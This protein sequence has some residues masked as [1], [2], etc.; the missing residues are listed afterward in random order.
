MATSSTITIIKPGAEGDDSDFE[1]P[2][3]SKKINR[4]RSQSA[5]GT[6]DSGADGS[7]LKP[8][9]Q[10]KRLNP[11]NSNGVHRPWTNM[12]KIQFARGIHQR[13]LLRANTLPSISR[14]K[15][16]QRSQDAS[17]TIYIPILIYLCVDA[18][19]HLQS[20]NSF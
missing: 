7:L 16:G 11:K 4:N 13:D 12:H 9:N 3:P 1:T 10:R 18:Y 20:R 19:I 8:D 14:A 17:C 6:E 2:L 5:P 15:V